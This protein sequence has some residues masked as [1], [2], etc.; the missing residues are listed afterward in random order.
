MSAP[1]ITNTPFP[2]MMM[3]FPAVEDVSPLIS[4]AP[5][6]QEV[7]AGTKVKL[8]CVADGV[9]VVWTY[10]DGTPL[11]RDSAISME[12]NGSLL[13]SPAD[14]THE[15]V[16]TCWALSTAGGTSHRQATLRVEAKRGTY[17]T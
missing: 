7:L 1:F 10:G 14:S 4:V 8:D 3:L 17:S 9:G 15:G 13:F 6:D 11:Y 16:Y 2:L 5:E 12:K